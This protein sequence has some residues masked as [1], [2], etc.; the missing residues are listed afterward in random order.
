MIGYTITTSESICS[1]LHDW[2]HLAS[3]VAECE[4]PILSVYLLIS[5]FCGNQLS[6]IQQSPILGL[7]L[8]LQVRR[9]AVLKVNLT[10]R[11]LDF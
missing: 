2:F 1:A 5:C 9:I 4:R 7:L 6:W 3:G 11:L 10:A 8:E